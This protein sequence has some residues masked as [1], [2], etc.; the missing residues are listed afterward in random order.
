LIYVDYEEIRHLE[1]RIIRSPSGVVKEFTMKVILDNKE[2]VSDYYDLSELG[3]KNLFVYLINTYYP[4]DK[5][6]KYL[7]QIHH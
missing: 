6:K 2:K 4:S 5:T 7:K 1:T 3:N